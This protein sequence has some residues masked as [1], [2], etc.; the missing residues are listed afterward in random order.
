MPL[1][2]VSP[3]ESA[4]GSWQLFATNCQVVALHTHNTCANTS[5]KPIYCQQAVPATYYQPHP[6]GASQ[7]GLLV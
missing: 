5:T 7:L 1:S 6:P 2:P 4:D 3:L